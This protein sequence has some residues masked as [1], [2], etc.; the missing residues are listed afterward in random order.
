M[1]LKR[2]KKNNREIKIG[3]SGSLSSTYVEN[4]EDFYFVAKPDRY[5]NI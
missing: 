2:T 5:Q 1:F 3:M 4:T